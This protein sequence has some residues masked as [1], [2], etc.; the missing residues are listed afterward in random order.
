MRGEGGIVTLLWQN[1]CQGNKGSS[2]FIGYCPKISRYNEFLFKSKE[3]KR[4]KGI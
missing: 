1:G 4:G 2:R 3:Q